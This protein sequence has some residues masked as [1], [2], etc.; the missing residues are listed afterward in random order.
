M[1]GEEVGICFGTLGVFGVCDISFFKSMIRL[2]GLMG[3]D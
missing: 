3:D 1:L 2:E